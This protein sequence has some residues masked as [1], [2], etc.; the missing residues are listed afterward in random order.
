[1]HRTGWCEAERRAAVD[2]SWDGG[3]RGDPGRLRDE[4]LGSAPT[5]GDERA[6]VSVL[7]AT[8]QRDRVTAGRA[9]EHMEEIACVK[10][11]CSC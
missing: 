8:M 11:R 3:G 5:V 7:G 1:M 6:E 10:Y 4:C 9:A 2:N